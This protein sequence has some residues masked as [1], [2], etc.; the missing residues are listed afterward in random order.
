MCSLGKE[1]VRV[2]H[3]KALGDQVDGVQGV[4]GPP[5]IFVRELIHFALVTLSLLRVGRKW[6]Q[7]LAGRW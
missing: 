7:I 2:L 6:M 5:A 3:T 4:M 1:V